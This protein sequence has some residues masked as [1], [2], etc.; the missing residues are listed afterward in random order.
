M[1]VVMDKKDTMDEMDMIQVEDS[2]LSQDT[3]GQQ[4]QQQY[5]FVRVVIHVAVDEVVIV[6]FYDKIDYYCYCCHEFYV[7]EKDVDDVVDVKLVILLMQLYHLVDSLIWV[8]MIDA[9]GQAVVAAD[10]LDYLTVCT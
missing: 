4:Q 6:D 7:D 10:F 5:Y 3:S 9:G 1:I 8:D 2:Y